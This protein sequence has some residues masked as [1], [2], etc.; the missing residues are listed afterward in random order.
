MALFSAFPFSM[1]NPFIRFFLRKGQCGKKNHYKHWPVKCMGFSES[2][3]RKCAT[4]F[5]GSDV[6]RLQVF[7]GTCFVSGDW[8]KGDCGMQFVQTCIHVAKVVRM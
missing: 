5:W 2:W 4:H 1:E 7:L 3:Q 6:H 8:E